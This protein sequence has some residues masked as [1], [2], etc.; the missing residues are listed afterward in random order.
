MSGERTAVISLG[1][2]VQST[3]MLLMAVEGCFDVVPEVAVFADTGW[4]P[5]GVYDHLDWLEA[6]VAGQIEIVRCTAGNLKDDLVGFA[7]GAGKRYASPPLFLSGQ[8]SKNGQLRR[9][10]TREYKIDPVKRALRDRGYGPK[11]PVDQWMGI[12]MDEIVRMKPSRTKWTQTRWPLIEKRMTRADCLAWFRERHPGREL[13]KSAC[14][15][16]PYHSDA[17][18]RD[19]RDN[20]PEAWEEAVQIDAQI[21]RLPKLEGD[22]FLHRQRVPLDQVDLTTPEDHGQLVLD[23]EGFDDECDG[24]CGT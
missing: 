20:Q 10:C 11:R 5:Q 6:E 13:V 3:T 9:Q 24:M 22:A 23:G 4:E 2:G 21:R 8:K 16:C 17:V 14:V 15:G 12:S 7:T 18:W 1:A 19:I